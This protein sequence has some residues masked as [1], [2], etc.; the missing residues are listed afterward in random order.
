MALR[1]SILGTT[2][3]LVTGATGFIGSRLVERLSELN[4]DPHN[5][6]STTSLV[7]HQKMSQLQQHESSA[8]LAS[9]I[10]NSDVSPSHSRI[11]VGDLTDRA[12]LKFGDDSVF[13]TVFHLAAV[14]PEATR[15]RNILRDVN[16]NGTLNLFDQ[17]RSATRHLV[18][19]SGVSAFET[20]N[21]EGVITEESRRSSEI[22][23][24]KM[25]LEV[26][27]YLRQNCR[28]A[29]IDYTVVHFPEIVYGNGGSF[30]RIFLE[31]I[32]HGSFRIPGSGD[33]Y[34]NFIHL[35]DAVNILITVA[36]IGEARNESYIATD[37]L[38]DLFKNFVNYIADQFG[39]KRPG[40]V[41]LILAKAVVGSDIIKMLTRS[42]KATNEK[43]KK[44]Y[45]FQYPSYREGI[46]DIVAKFNSAEQ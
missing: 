29:G 23:Y 38:P 21:K 37:S 41:P 27:E 26:E 10:A 45:D 25:R 22:D 1:N 11:I 36:A 40:T 13:D 12:S 34:T 3:V 14:T 28:D 2:S 32:K 17:I 24:I 42:A 6:I 19:V 9:S 8:T 46:P 39:V 18:Y 35:D 4:K 43:I 15:N 20:D 44:I 7:R 5:H 16:Y 31:R 33:Y 30:R